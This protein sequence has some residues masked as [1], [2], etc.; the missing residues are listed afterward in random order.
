MVLLIARGI[1]GVIKMSL[2]EKVLV[3]VLIVS[4]VIGSILAACPVLLNIYDRCI[5]I[6]F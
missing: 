2:E 3:V 4:F 6:L 1:K 5:S